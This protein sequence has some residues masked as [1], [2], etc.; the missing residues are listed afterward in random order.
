MAFTELE[1]K[2]K[3][4]TELKKV[5]AN[6]G[7][8]RFSVKT[9]SELIRDILA[10]QEGKLEPIVHKRGRPSKALIEKEKSLEAEN[11]NVVTEC[12]EIGVMNIEDLTEGKVEIEP[13]EFNVAKENAV[14]HDSQKQHMYEDEIP[15]PEYKDGAIEVAEFSQDADEDNVDNPDEIVKNKGES[16]DKSLRGQRTVVAEIRDDIKA[17]KLAGST[18]SNAFPSF[19][20]TEHNIANFDVTGIIEILPENYGYLR[21]LN[22]YPSDADLYVPLVQIKRFS[23]RNGDKLKV[24]GRF[25][26]NNRY[27]SVIFI[28]E[29]NDIPCDQLTFRPNFVDL[30]PVYPTQRLRLEDGEHRLDV[31]LRLIDLVSPIGRG[32]RGLIISP[33]K[34]GKTT[35][36]KSIAQAI[37]RNYTDIEMTMLLVDERPEEVTDIQES[38][39]GAEIVYS[40]F[41]MPPEHHTKVAELVMKNAKRRVELGKHVVILLDS[42]TR[43]SRAY[44][45]VTEQTGKTL[46]GGL[47]SAALFEPKRF[48]G[49]ARSIKNGGSLTIIA[50][51]LVDTG[52]KMDDIIY[53]EF[54]GTGNMEIHL[55]RRLSE[56]RIFPAVDLNK[57]GTRREELLLSSKEMEGMWLLRRILSRSDVVDATEMLLDRI[58]ATKNNSEFIDTLKSLKPFNS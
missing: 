31:A 20:A 13:K 42:I 32:Q 29:I 55:S 27:A 24:K 37:L 39:Q 54:K 16:V 53:E 11:K 33:P 34:A 57:S 49:A 10:I 45:Q 5:A 3:N 30:V 36:L 23:L 7:V 26:P 15:D 4:I 58:M 41:D 50:S 48:F 25:F 2:V 12:S 22:Y 51:A 28:Y 19:T 35:L 14:L 47:D 18:D 38:V 43:L 8:A 56:R 40:T 46:T 9:S 6:L 52:S 44:N 1:L 17:K 21:T